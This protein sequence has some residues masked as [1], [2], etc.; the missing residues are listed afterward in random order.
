M[1]GQ[2]F[3]MLGVAWDSLRP[4]SDRLLRRI[5]ISHHT[6]CLCD[7]EILLGISDPVYYEANWVFKAT[8]LTSI[9]NV[10]RENTENFPNINKMYIKYLNKVWLT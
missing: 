6:L 2:H 3:I 7:W 4:K 10:V 5:T 9:N 1:S 8:E